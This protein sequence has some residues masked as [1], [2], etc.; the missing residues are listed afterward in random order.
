MHDQHHASQYLPP[1]KTSSSS[2]AS[3]S[4]YGEH[5]L[6]MVT[7]YHRYTMNQSIT[8]EAKIN[9]HPNPAFQQRRVPPSS[10]NLLHSNYALSAASINGHFE[11]AALKQ[12]TLPPNISAATPNG[13]LPPPTSSPA[14]TTASAIASVT[15]NAN[16]AAPYK[17]WLWNSNLF[18]PQSRTIHDGFL[19]YSSHLSGFFANKSRDLRA[20]HESVAAM[21]TIDLS[22][23]SYCSDANSDSD[24]LDVSDDKFSPNSSPLSPPRA[25]HRQT[26]AHDSMAT[27]PTATNT[28]KKRNPYSIEELL[29]KP[30]KRMR[31]EPIAFHPSILIHNVEHGNVVQRPGDALLRRQSSVDNMCKTEINEMDSKN[32]NNSNLKIEVCD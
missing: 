4:V 1:N 28:A 15:P 27:S 30:E 17:H 8:A 18:Y 23:S 2:S 20:P 10:L 3:A 31:T 26:R 19:P 16:S 25:M 24:S 13:A 14:A 12:A 9:Q 29:K 5:P 32:N 6:P 7:S 11:I 21:K 22:S